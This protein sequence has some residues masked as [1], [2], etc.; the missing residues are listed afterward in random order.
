MNIEKR[1]AEEAQKYVEENANGG[2]KQVAKESYLLAASLEDM[3]ASG[4]YFQGEAQVEPLSTAVQ[5][6]KDARDNVV[7]LN[8][9]R[10]YIDTSGMTADH[11]RAEFTRNAVASTLMVFWCACGLTGMSRGRAT[12]K[13]FSGPGARL[14]EEAV[15]EWN[16][17]KESLREECLRYI[18]EEKNKKSEDEEIDIHKEEKEDKIICKKCNTIVRDGKGICPKC[19][20][21]MF[22]EKYGRYKSREEKSKYQEKEINIDKSETEEIEKLVCQKCRVVVRSNVESCPK[23]G[24]ELK[25]EELEELEERVGKEICPKCG[26]NMFNEKYGRYKSREEKSKYQEKEIN[27]DKSE[28]EE[29]EKLVCQKCRVVVRSNVESCPK[30]GRELKN[31]E[32]EELEERVGKEQSSSSG[33]KELKC[34]SCSRVRITGDDAQSVQCSVCGSKMHPASEDADRAPVSGEADRAS[35]SKDT[36]RSSETSEDCFVAT[37]VYSDPGHPDVCHLRR[38]RDETLRRSV[39]GR[40]FIA[41]YYRYGPDLAE[42]IEDTPFLK[43]GIRWT[44]GRLVGVLEGG[45][46][47]PQRQSF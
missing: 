44:L 7:E 34:P 22:N 9:S 24:R 17:F 38:F 29:I 27:I 33:L 10:G 15:K 41:W 26:S 3:Y 46:S 1:V 36:D 18:E 12:K 25:N 37:A 28:T 32:L 39:L 40:I 16:I 35:V 21:N 23:C 20:S 31:E 30:C 11:A 43:R 47:R 4:Q 42:Y 45:C 8:R 6:A 14:G 19:G 2:A 13:V 5:A